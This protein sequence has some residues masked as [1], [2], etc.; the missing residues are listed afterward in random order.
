MASYEKPTENLAEFNNLVFTDAAN[1]TLTLSKAK[2]LFLG[3]T[4]TPNSTATVTTFTGQIAANTLTS[5]TITNSTVIYG[6]LYD[7][8]LSANSGGYCKLFSN[9][10]VDDVIVIGNEDTTTDLQGQNLNVTAT[11]TTFSNATNITNLSSTNITNS[12][13]IFSNIYNRNLASG[14]GGFCELFTNAES[15]DKIEI[16]NTVSTTYLR[17]QAVNIPATT[18]TITNDIFVNGVR[19]G[20]GNSTDTTNTCFGRDA[21]F[22]LSTVD[23]TNNNCAFGRDALKLFNRTNSAVAN[24]GY[25][26]AFGAFSLQA[27]TTGFRNVG[28]GTFSLGQVGAT[29]LTT[30]NRN[31]S[32]GYASGFIVS[33]AGSDNTYIGCHRDNSAYTTG[34]TNTF[35]GSQ[36]ILGPGTN[37]LLTVNASTTL[38]AFTSVGGFSNSTAIGGGTSTGVPGAVCTA[39]NQIM[40]GRTT[41]T[42]YCPGVPTTGSTTYTSLVLSGGLQLQTAYSIAPSANMLGYRV[43]TTGT[44]VVLTSTTTSNLVNVSVPVGVWNVS[45]SVSVTVT[46]GG[47]VTA[48][49]IVFSATTA[50][51]TALSTICGQSKTHSSDTYATN[52]VYIVSNSVEYQT[53]A[54]TNIYLNMVCTFSGGAALTATGYVS[55]TRMG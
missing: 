13:D 29:A 39:A 10:T 51:T 2:S 22:T 16:G 40:L 52:D 41:E 20:K 35:V 32:C 36:S 9:A 14:N 45:Y 23:T 43:V 55:L 50:S 26:S 5:D 12:N 49:N 48:Q 3:R 33:G 4:G 53:T 17:G 6:N 42:V 8:N 7:R 19:A 31:T 27:I 1:E 38:G 47:N 15:T 28:I 34:S 11:T 21:L 30:G 24:T 44:A 54:A 46:S 18:T 37:T 25:N